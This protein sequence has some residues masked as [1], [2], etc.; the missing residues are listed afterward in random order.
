MKKEMKYKDLTETARKGLVKY[1]S[2]SSNGMG[3]YADKY[4]KKTGRN[5]Y[6]ISNKEHFFSWVARN[7]IRTNR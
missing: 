3:K 5:P 4:R 2:L 1:A 6:S 7:R